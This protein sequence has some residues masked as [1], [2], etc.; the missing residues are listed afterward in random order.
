MMQRQHDH[1]R[2]RTAPARR[3]PHRRAVALRVVDDAAPTAAG[4]DPI[5]ARALQ[6][7]LV[8]RFEHGVPEEPPVRRYPPAVRLALLLASTACLWWSLYVLS[9]LVL[10]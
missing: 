1:A 2:S 7:R 5:H 3:A 4:T 10:G 9:R 8:H 6:Q